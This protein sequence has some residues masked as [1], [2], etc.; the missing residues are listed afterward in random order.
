MSYKGGKRGSEE[1]AR[2]LDWSVREA[3]M[4]AWNKVLSKLKA[5]GNPYQQHDDVEAMPRVPKA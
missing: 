4:A 1:T 2:C 3:S 5:P